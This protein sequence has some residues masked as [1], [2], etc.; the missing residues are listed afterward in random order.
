MTT[1]KH[2][3]GQTRPSTDH[4]LA[5]QSQLPGTRQGC[6]QEN[7][8]RS[9]SPHKGQVPPLP[10]VVPKLWSL[11]HTQQQP[12]TARRS[13]EFECPE[14][15]LKGLP[16]AELSSAMPLSR[17]EATDLGGAARTD[18]GKRPGWV[19]RQAAS[20]KNGEGSL[21]GHPP[22]Q[23]A[24]P[25]PNSC[26]PRMALAYRAGKQVRASQSYCSGFG[27]KC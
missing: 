25:D 10:Q 17:Q 5:R 23:G 11:L 13:R 2:S 24:E 18:L 19:T 7:H 20:R 8:M 12:F 1:T 21:L 6:H 16:A 26:L 22:N 27:N 14:T 3:L 4:S 15:L 9:F